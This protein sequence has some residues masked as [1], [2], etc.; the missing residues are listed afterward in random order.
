MYEYNGLH[1]IL[2]SSNYDTIYSGLFP[3]YLKSKIKKKD[4]SIDLQRL[5]FNA[6]ATF[7]KDEV[8]SIETISQEVFLKNYPKL[9]YDI[10]SINS[11][12]ISTIKKIKLDKE[13]NCFFAKP[14]NSFIENLNKVDEI[15]YKNESTNLSIIGNGI[16]GY[17]IAY[18][19]KQRYQKKIHIN[20]IGP[21]GTKEKNINNECHKKLKEIAIYLNIIEYKGRVEKIDKTT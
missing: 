12:S 7:I 21:T 15:I 6:G 5:C 2:I 3:L 9:K 16:A 8:L 1:T 20:L 19:L 10:L 11:G 18:N 17:E 14:I 13:A 4:I